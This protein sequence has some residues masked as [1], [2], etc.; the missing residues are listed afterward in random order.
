MN[1]MSLKSGCPSFSS[2]F[3][4]ENS[5]LINEKRVERKPVVSAKL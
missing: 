5:L 3:A 2:Y 4:S 1:G